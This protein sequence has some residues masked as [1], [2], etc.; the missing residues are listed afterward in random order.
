[1]RSALRF[2]AV[3]A[4]LALSGPLAAAQE[5]PA[6][7]K[8]QPAVG[9]AARAA[10]AKKKKK[11]LG[12]LVG[13]P[14]LEMLPDGGSRIFLPISAPLT[15][16]EHVS[17]GQLSYVLENGRIDVYNSENAL[18]TYYFNTPV[19]RARLQRLKKKDL[20]LVIFLRADV[21]ATYRVVENKNGTVRLEVDFPPGTYA[22]DGAGR[23]PPPP[24]PPPK[25]PA[26]PKAPPAK[27]APKAGPPAP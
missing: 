2:G 24:A 26:K 12:P 6:P 16:T 27:P 14:G 4:A 3:L 23:P 11:E 22:N 15:I 18:E 25:E 19:V 5:K 7:A 1:M 8:P 20:Q 9:P 10:A 21:K 17:P 13:S